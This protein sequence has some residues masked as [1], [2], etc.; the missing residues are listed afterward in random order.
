MADLVGGQEPLARV[1]E[2]GG[3]A[4]ETVLC[5]ENKEL[6]RGWRVQLSRKDRLQEQFPRNPGSTAPEM[7]A[8]RKIKEAQPLT[9]WLMDH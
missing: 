3:R 4:S 5:T 7:A 9:P 6:E 1:R 2:P 8:S